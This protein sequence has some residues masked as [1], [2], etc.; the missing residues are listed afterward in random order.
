MSSVS[1][2]KQLHPHQYKRVAL[3]PD[4]IYSFGIYFT[5]VTV[6]STLEYHCF[7]IA[8]ECENVAQSSFDTIYRFI[9]Q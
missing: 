3:L 1:P 9:F 6:S 4:F 7:Q 2:G 8:T 5:L